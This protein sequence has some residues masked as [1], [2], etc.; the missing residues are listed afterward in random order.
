VAQAT[1]NLF[2]S[3]SI[4]FL[5]TV[6]LVAEAVTILPALSIADPNFFDTNGNTIKS[7]EVG[8]QVVISAAFYENLAKQ[9]AFVGLV[10]VRDTSDVTQFL[11]WQNSTVV[12]RGNYTNSFVWLVEEPSQY[13]VVRV[14]AISSFEQAES[15]SFIYDSEIDACLLTNDRNACEMAQPS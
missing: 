6:P 13:Y 2:L 12:P 4:T 8:D 9:T 11:V 3:A 5:L 14:Y 15:L 1:S 7:I 10:E